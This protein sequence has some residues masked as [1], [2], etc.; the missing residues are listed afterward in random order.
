VDTLSRALA[1]VG[2][3]K[4]TD[5]A[6][7]ISAV[8]AFKE[9]DEQLFDMREFWEH[10]IRCALASSWLASQTETEKEETYFLAGLLHD[11]GWLI[12]LKLYPDQ[13]REAL[14]K[15][16]F[17]PRPSYL[18]EKDIWGFD[19]AE[20][21]GMALKAWQLPDSIVNGVMHHHAPH[22]VKYEHT[23]SIIHIS[24][25]VSHALNIKVRF[26]PM[27]PMRGGA[28]SALGLTHNVF[29]PMAT[30]IDAQLQEILGVFFS[31]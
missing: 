10:S 16:K 26:E 6:L 14:I 30:Q 9:I 24:D 23:S 27:P 29:A 8:S 21:G 3:D 4:L 18:V 28:W 7:G 11:I 25:F 22:L 20:L 17:D 12:M 19:H 31:G 15:R 1:L 5:L 13:A 2:M